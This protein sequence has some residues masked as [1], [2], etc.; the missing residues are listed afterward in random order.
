MAKQ[1]PSELVEFLSLLGFD[2]PD[3]DEDK[4]HEMGRAWE[5]FATKLK[6]FTA[7]ADRHAQGVWTGN[8]GAAIEAFQKSWT[9]PE[10]PLANLRDGAAA[11]AIIA[12]GMHTAAEAVLFLKGKMIVEAAF[13]ARTCVW[14]AR[15]AKTPW[16]A[17][18]AV[19]AVIAVRIACNMAISAAVEEALKRLMDE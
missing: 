17:A 10:A 14:A 18:G 6:E 9:G 1:L 2:W 3:G 19:A 7:E 12:V 15:A 5:S 8:Q 11:A 4:L 16:T 13:F